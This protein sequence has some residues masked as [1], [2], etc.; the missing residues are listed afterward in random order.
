MKNN[1]AK[2]LSVQYLG[3]NGIKLVPKKY[4]SKLSKD[5]YPPSCLSIW[6]GKKL[7][8][9]PD[10]NYSDKEIKSIRKYELIDIHSQ[11]KE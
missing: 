7:I 5:I 6:K 10:I 3:E 4:S 8:A 1:H 11:L 9:V 2:G